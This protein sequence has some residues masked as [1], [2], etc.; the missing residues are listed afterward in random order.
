M[1]KTKSVKVVPKEA[2]AEMPKKALV[3][4]VAKK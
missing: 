4:K 3:K 1:A 2:K